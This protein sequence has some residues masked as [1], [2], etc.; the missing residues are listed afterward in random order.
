[1]RKNIKFFAIILIGIVV[2]CFVLYR[3]EEANNLG[4]YLKNIDNAIQA[5]EKYYNEVSDANRI[6]FVEALKHLV[7]MYAEI[8]DRKN[9]DEAYNAKLLCDFLSS[10]YDILEVDKN[11]AVQ[12]NDLLDGLHMLELDS[13]DESGR[14]I[15]C[16]LNFVKANS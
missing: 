14:A 4:N 16:I 3:S 5:G 9:G 11:Y 8:R 15:D 13:V 1:M 7:V 10:S 12:L 6:E 2:I